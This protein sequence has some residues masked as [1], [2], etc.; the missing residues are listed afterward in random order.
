MFGAED[1]DA[2]NN[3]HKKFRYHGFVNDDSGRWARDWWNF[4]PNDDHN[5]NHGDPTGE[6][7][8]PDICYR[9]DEHGGGGNGKY[10]RDHP[11]PT[12]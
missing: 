3:K 5:E 8:G 11:N 7:A 2:R 6:L 4:H 10:M 1:P 9:D 12:S